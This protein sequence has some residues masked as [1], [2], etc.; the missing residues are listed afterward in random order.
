MAAL[1]ATALAG[2]ST[3]RVSS[4]PTKE[5]LSER[6]SPQDCVRREP[7]IPFLT[8]RVVEVDTLLCQ[9]AWLDA[10]LTVTEPKPGGTAAE[11]LE[12]S[13]EERSVR[14]DHAALLDQLAARLAPAKN[15][16]PREAKELGDSLRAIPALSSLEEIEKLPMS[17]IGRVRSQLLEIAAERTFFL[18]AVQPL[19]GSATVSPELTNGLLSKATV[20]VTSDFKPI[21]DPLMKKLFAAPAAAAATAPAA[22]AL[23]AADPGPATLRVEL[24]VTPVSLDYRVTP[25]AKQPAPEC[26]WASVSQARFVRG[27]ADE[28]GQT[29]AAPAARPQDRKAIGITGEITLPK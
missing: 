8:Q 6:C 23:A 5:L 26:T 10:E 4:M 15:Y 29:P 19:F 11:R 27:K 1:A 21:V 20:T 28:F 7:G 16:T 24:K 22:A 13:R 17:T 18:N 3:V 25:S 14:I 9:Q 12:V 2:C